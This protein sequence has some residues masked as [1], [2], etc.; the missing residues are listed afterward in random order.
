MDSPAS[1]PTK[2]SGNRLAI[3]SILSLTTNVL[4]LFLSLL[5][6]PLI[7]NAYGLELFGVL[8]VTWMVLANL[9]WLDLGFSRAAARFVAQDLAAGEPERA[10]SWA[11]TAIL[12]QAVIGGC[13]ALAV[14]LLA[15]WLTVMLQVQPAR[16]DMVILTL[17]LFAFA[18]PIELAT[19]SVSGVLAAGERFNWLNSLNLMSTG[20]MYLIYTIGILDDANFSVVIY[21]LFAL[22]LLGLVGTFVGAIKVL[23]ALKRLPNLSFI[24]SSYRSHASVMINYGW[25]VAV[26]ALLGAMLLY[27]DQ[28]LI[29][30]VLGISILPFFLVPFNLLGRLAIFTASLTVTLFPAF[31]SLQATRDWESIQ[32]YFARS[33]RYVLMALVPILF[34]VFVW[35]SEILR[36]WISPEFSAGAALPLRIL[37][38]GFGVA[39][40]GPISGALLEAV[41]RPDIVVKLYLVEVPFNV[42]IVLY[43]TREFG[44]AGAAWSYTIRAILE[45]LTVLIVLHRTLPISYAYFLKSAIIP[46]TP[47]IL[48]VSIVAYLVEGRI[49][50]P[51]SIIATFAALAGYAVYASLVLL[52][53]K[54]WQLVNYFKDSFRKRLSS[55]T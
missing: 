23:P 3:N 40:A 9:A 22:R 28:W 45:T 26:A 51:V 29:G 27:F 32:S 37:V 8:S 7:I 19:R 4:V 1:R 2:V 12:T 46:M 11:W 52:D 38:I 30:F 14:F 33:H 13:G 18:L 42:A 16:Q 21:G 34:V 10:V 43:L 41:G 44:V 39:L 24:V 17:Q 47:A 55:W 5:F 6:M 31:S 20:L 49:N 36:L 48:A 50:D 15:P 35:S 54:D 25:W 53:D